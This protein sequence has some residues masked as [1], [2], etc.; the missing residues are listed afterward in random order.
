MM[1]K[2][3]LV[4]GPQGVGKTAVVRRAQEVLE[5][6][7]KQKFEIINF[8]DI[9][10][11]IVG[12]DRDEF[13]RTARLKEFGK[14]QEKTADRI[15]KM[16]EDDKSIF[17]TSHALLWRKAGFVPGFPISVL[18]KLKPNSI[19]LIMADPADVISRKL[20]DELSGK[21]GKRTRDRVSAENIGREANAE[22]L[23]S[24]SYAMYTGAPVKTII[25]KEGRLDEAVA[26]LVEA[27]NNI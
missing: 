13:R 17:L 12:G 4:L 26:K 19:V 24:Y 9:L 6:D 11:E 20:K 15:S 5:K 1:A 18:A 7:F 16:I 8:G 3:V 21:E 25:N 2:L 10:Q 27:V 14:V 22:E 23:I